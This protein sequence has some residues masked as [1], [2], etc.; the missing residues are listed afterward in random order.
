MTR[1]LP[2]ISFSRLPWDQTPLARAAASTAY[3]SDISTYCLS[4][5]HLQSKG[6]EFD[7][8][9]RWKMSNWITDLR[10]G[11]TKR[12]QS[13]LVDPRSLIFNQI[14]TISVRNF[15]RLPSHW[16]F[17]DSKTLLGRAN[18]HL[19]QK[20]PS[21]HGLLNEA[22]STF[23]QF[24]PNIFGVKRTIELRTFTRYGPASK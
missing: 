3:L 17:T 6:M 20:I 2:F 19:K 11:Q 10:T 4:S 21:S 5:F 16:A 13:L 18:F 22:S 7:G 1:F 14:A 15:L 12:R 9:W 8:V 23:S 24:S